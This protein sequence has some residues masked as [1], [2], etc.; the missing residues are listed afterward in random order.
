MEGIEITGYVF[1]GIFF[2]FSVFH[3]VVCFFENEK[4][5]KITKIFCLVLLAIAACFLAYRHPLIYV[6]AILGAVGDYFLLKKNPSMITT[7]SCRMLT[8][9]SWAPLSA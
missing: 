3:L 6:G 5:R 8:G 7:S 1:L 2:S 9:L 4:L